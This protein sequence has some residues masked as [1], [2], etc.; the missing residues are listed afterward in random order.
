MSIS[1]KNINWAPFERWARRFKAVS[2]AKLD[3]LFKEDF[4]EPEDWLFLQKRDEI[5]CANG[6]D[7]DI[8]ESELRR[9][10]HTKIYF[11]RRYFA[12]VSFDGETFF[13]RCLK[14]LPYQYAS[15]CNNCIGVW[16]ERD[17]EK[18]HLNP[19][20][21]IN[22]FDISFFCKSI[23]DIDLASMRAVLPFDTIFIRL[24]KEIKWTKTA[25]K[26]L[27]Q[28]IEEDLRF[29]EPVSIDFEFNNYPFLSFTV[30][31]L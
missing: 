12:D 8:D 23:K 14:V 1:L 19:Y 11:F 21:Q 15:R 10:I 31:D 13:D 25:A 22:D 3:E 17:L 5:G 29:D 27:K 7:C 28:Q 26:N 4:I 30:T 18:L 2:H 24:P 6:F 20:Q 9:R 16:L